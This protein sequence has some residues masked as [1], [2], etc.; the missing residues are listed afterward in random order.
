MPIMQ[1][2]QEVVDVFF[3]LQSRLDSRQRRAEIE[4]RMKSQELKSQTSISS[5][6]SGKPYWLHCHGL[7][8]RLPSAR[9]SLSVLPPVSLSASTACLLACFA[10]LPASLSTC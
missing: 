8:L 3:L 10:A 5:E 6:R 4:R 1:E 9:L 2:I 7:P